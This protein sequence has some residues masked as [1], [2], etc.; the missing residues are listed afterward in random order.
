MSPRVFFVMMQK[1]DPSLSRWLRHYTKLVPPQHLVILDN[2][3]SNETTRGLLRKAETLGVSVIYSMSSHQHFIDKAVHLSTVIDAIEDDGQ[4]FA[5]PV[6]CDELLAVF[7]DTGLSIAQD[8]IM[9][10]FARLLTFDCTF[11]IEYS[12][13]NVPEAPHWYYP[14]HY[15]KGF[16]KAGQLESL[17]HGYHNPVSIREKR[18]ELTRFAYLH[19]HNPAW[20]DWWRLARLKFLHSWDIDVPEQR[21]ALLAAWPLAGRHMLEQI[22]DGEASYLNKYSDEFQVQW[23]PECSGLIRIREPNDA[24]VIWNGA[25]YLRS[26]PDVAAHYTLG[27]LYHYIAHGRREGR[28]LRANLL[29][30]TQESRK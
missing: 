23:N 15:Q 13:H 22:R 17:D 26:N 10:E 24:P 19:Y 28:K 21:A 20:A 12:L 2:G 30:S 5:V 27:A 14:K 6:D 1:D 18:V 11:R 29:T 16:T 25:A 7:T 9:A 3:S 8:D 4:T